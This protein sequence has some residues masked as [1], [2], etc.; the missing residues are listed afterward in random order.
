MAQ[1]G[2]VFGFLGPNGA[3]KTTSV[4]MLLSPTR[5]AVKRRCWDNRL[6]IARRASQSRISS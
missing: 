3:G 6:V 1:R 4:K 2:E 5:L